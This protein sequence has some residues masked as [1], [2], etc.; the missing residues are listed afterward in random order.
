MKIKMLFKIWD[1]AFGT[2][3]KKYN[4]S[5]K[6]LARKENCS[7]AAKAGLVQRFFFNSF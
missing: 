3:N 2:E 4:F 1:R 5:L 7:F 6:K